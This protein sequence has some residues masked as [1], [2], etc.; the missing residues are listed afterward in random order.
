MD[1]HGNF[2]RGQGGRGDYNDAGKYSNLHAINPN[3][4][5]L[6]P[7]P[8]TLNPEPSILNPE[9]LTLHPEPCTVNS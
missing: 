3:P 9:V 8:R 1:N 7:E 6:N 2:A 5:T 4:W